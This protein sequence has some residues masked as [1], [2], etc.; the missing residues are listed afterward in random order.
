[1]IGVKKIMRTED[2]KI[3]ENIC[4]M[5]EKELYR[6]VKTFLMS[7]PFNSFNEGKNYFIAWGSLDIALVAHLD[8]V[9]DF[10]P[11]ELFYDR[12]KDTILTLGQGAGFDD[13]AGVYAILK[14]LTEWKDV[15]PTIIFTLGEEDYGVGAREAASDGLKEKAKRLKYMIELD[16]QG[17]DDCVFYQCI[18]RDFQ[19]YVSS[20]GFKK[21]PGSY[22]D[23][24]FLMDEWQTCG[25][26][27]SI[28]YYDEHT[29]YEYLRPSQ[30]EVTIIRVLKML[31]DI[32]N[33]SRFRY[34]RVVACNCD[35]C[36]QPSEL[37]DVNTINGHKRYCINCLVEA[38]NYCPN[39]EQLISMEDTNFCPVCGKELV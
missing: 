39:C 14:I 24:Y 25:V 3:L 19:S 12:D 36:G 38:C 18:S 5:K 8:T 30:M 34:K 10:P 23:I 2:F 17:K 28:G 7:L 1:M 37:I 27:L 16:R 20:F 29:D 32:K 31:K 4:S 26:N 21:Q 22:S 33:V 9:F 6:F 11:Q 13:R 15:P 35:R